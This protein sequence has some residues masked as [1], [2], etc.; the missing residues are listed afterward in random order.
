VLD[1]Q[2]IR[3]GLVGA[4]GGISKR[5][6]SAILE[7]PDSEV[8]LICETDENKWEKLKEKYNVKITKDYREVVSSPEVDAVA[9]STPN[10]FHYEIIKEALKNG[11]HTVS[12]YPMVQNLAQYDELVKLAEGKKVV[13][14]DGLTPRLEIQHKT[15]MNNLPRFGRLMSANYRYFAEGVN[16][17]Y[18][19]PKLAGDFFCTCH[20]HFIDYQMAFFGEVESIYA[21]K[22]MLQKECREIKTGYAVMKFK[23]GIY[24]VIEFGVGFT[25]ASP[26]TLLVTGEQGYIEYRGDEHAMKFSGKTDKEGYFEI[27]LPKVDTFAETL[28][29]DTNLFIDEILGRRKPVVDSKLGREILRI[30]LLASESAETGKVI[31][32]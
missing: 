16:G 21:T 3:F 27:E 25:S 15:I 32:T 24:S 30:T 31:K 13:L 14:H 20:M 19:N 6:G 12:E 1:K 17:W 28:K 10:I 2:K 5:R 22:Y 4:G 9:I 18:W 23:N 11:K 8:T 7:N 26:N 29:E